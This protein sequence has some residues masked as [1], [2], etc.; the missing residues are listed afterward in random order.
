M[1]AIFFFQSLKSSYIFSTSS[2]S[3]FTHRHTEAHTHS[4]NIIS[5][6]IPSAM[7]KITSTPVWDQSGYFRNKYSL[8]GQMGQATIYVSQSECTRRS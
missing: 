6:S 7:I 2:A 3:H 4:Q 5:F 1:I 8:S